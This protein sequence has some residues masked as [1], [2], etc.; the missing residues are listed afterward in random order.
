MLGDGRALANVHSKGL[1][2]PVP[3]HADVRAHLLRMAARTTSNRQLAEAALETQKRRTLQRADESTSLLGSAGRAGGSSERD[4]GAT[5][6]KL[7]P[8]INDYVSTIQEK[9][10]DEEDMLTMYSIRAA[11]RNAGFFS[12]IFATW[13]FGML[14]HGFKTIINKDYA[15]N[16]TDHDSIPSLNN[17]F[18]REFDKRMA[19][20]TCLC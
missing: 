18:A 4:G 7:G 6:G 9:V 5:F 20:G 3:M 1:R 15:W 19:A 17:K 10:N 14:R 13:Q 16:L 2:A 12:R 11:R 8:Y